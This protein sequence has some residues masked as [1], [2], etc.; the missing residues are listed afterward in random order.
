MCGIAGM[1]QMTGSIGRDGIEAVER[2]NVAQRHRGPDDSGLFHDGFA[3]LGHRRLS[4]ID[5]S[6]AGRQPMENE[7]GSVQVIYNGEIYNYRELRS[8]LCSAGHQFRSQSDTEVILHGYEQWG[9]DGLLPR[10]RGMFAFALYDAAR[11][12]SILARDR[13]GIKPLYYSLDE[14]TG[15]LAFASEVKALAEA[16]LVSK[17]VDRAALAGF[18]LLGSVPAPATIYRGVRCLLPGHFAVA[19][20]GAFKTTRYWDLPP[21]LDPEANGDCLHRLEALPETLRDAVTRHLISD[22]PLGVFLSGGVDSAGLVAL[23]RHSQQNLKTVTISFAESEFDEAAEAQRIARHF[24]AE[25][26]EA[27][28]TAADFARELPRILAAMDQ[29]TN[30]GVNSYFVARAA[31]EAGL[32]VVLSGLGADELF[33]GYPHYHFMARH[34][35]FLRRLANAPSLVRKICVSGAVAAGN[36]RGRESW[37]RL[38]A[39]RPGIAAEGLYFAFRGFFAREQ[40]Q[41]LMGLGQS[42]V[43][44]LLANYVEIRSRDLPELPR[45]DGLNYIE[46]KRY[47]HDQLLRDTDVFSMA[48]SI[49]VRVPYLDNEVVDLAASL[50]ASLKMSGAMNK[51]LLVSA[52]GDDLV[53]QAARRRKRGFSF[54]LGKWIG[55]SAGVMREMALGRDLLDEQAVR[56]LWTSF[57]Q[58]RLHWSRA[59]SLVVLGART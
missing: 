18:L 2:M 40:V 27:R 28:V 52:I 14:R 43:D 4:I 50:P 17:D 46:L 36:I 34:A 45:A 41:R 51:P 37:K 38:G 48:H 39:L 32:T 59:W 6:A 8:Q 33:G 54:P 47:L 1:I 7:T 35:A 19:E 13:L 42:E 10:L 20:E 25:H 24:Q 55:E 5:V 15:R 3:V 58:G 26:H 12:R 57:E 29:P 16:G 11:R 56:K 23:A 44:D 9:E 22:V 30:D 53:S 49:E 21:R 31:R